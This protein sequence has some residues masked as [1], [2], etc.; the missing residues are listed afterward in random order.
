M[1][2]KANYWTF[3][4]ETE[5]DAASTA[6]RGD[7]CSLQSGA[8]LWRYSGSAWVA[9]GGGSSAGILGVEDT[10]DSPVGLWTLDGDLLDSSGS[11]TAAPVSV[12]YGTAKYSTRGGRQW[13][14]FD[15]DT[16][17]TAGN[18]SKLVGVGDWSIACTFCYD[19]PPLSGVAYLCG[20]FDDA[21]STS[22]YNSGEFLWSNSYDLYSI[23]EYGSG[24][25]QSRAWLS[26]YNFLEDQAGTFWDIVITRD[27]STKEKI[28]YI[29]GQNVDSYTYTTDPTGGTLCPF[30]IGGGDNGASAVNEMNFALMGNVAAYDK[31]LTPAEVAAR[32]TRLVGDSS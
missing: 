1:A 21:N 4:N 6:A 14:Y 31:T 18:Q 22:D 7:V 25:D 26:S 3:E 20:T 17:L 27:V 29:N 11:G 2:R 12:A 5:R 28:I 19:V 8:G 30:Y 13:A 10:T 24:T 32:A 16:V 15:G 9:E 23:H